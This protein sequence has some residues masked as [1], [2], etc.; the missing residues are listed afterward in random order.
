LTIE[1]TAPEKLS[2]A[3]LDKALEGDEQIINDD[4]EIASDDADPLVSADLDDG[5]AE[6]AEGAGN[7]TVPAK[8]VT[9]PA[10][11]LEDRLAKLEKR[12]VDKDRFIEERNAEIGRLR[13]QV[14]EPPKKLHDVNADTFFEDPIANVEKITENQRIKLEQ[15]QQR[16][17]EQMREMITHRRSITQQIAP[18]YEQNLDLVAEV[19]KQDGFDED[20]I[21]AFRSNPF[22]YEPPLLHNLNLRAKLAKENADLKAEINR[23]KGGPKKILDKVETMSRQRPRVTGNSASAHGEGGLDAETLDEKAISKLSDAQL[24]ALLAKSRR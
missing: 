18:D 23:L 19:L 24:K 4:G 11:T 8:A 5:E 14:T 12:L 21:K 20:G 15:E 9:P 2:D 17:E 3:D 16:R 10:E 22:A 1:I 6:G 13:K 7:T